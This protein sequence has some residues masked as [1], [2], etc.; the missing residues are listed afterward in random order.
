MRVRSIQLQQAC[1]DDDK[2]DSEECR[3]DLRAGSVSK[4]VPE[5]HRG[6]GKQRDRTLGAEPYASRVSFE[7]PLL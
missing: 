2:I 5:R 4:V 3:E 7:L 1:R 6:D